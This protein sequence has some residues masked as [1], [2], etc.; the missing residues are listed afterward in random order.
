MRLHSSLS[1]GAYVKRK[2]TPLGTL[3]SKKIESFNF[4]RNSNNSFHDISYNEDQNS[5]IKFDQYSA[6]PSTSHSYISDNSRSISYSRQSVEVASLFDESLENFT[7]TTSTLLHSTIESAISENRHILCRSFSSGAGCSTALENLIMERR[8]IDPMQI[9][10]YMP[11]QHCREHKDFLFQARRVFPSLGSEIRRIQTILESKEFLK[12]Q[13]IEI[14]NVLQKSTL[15]IE[16]NSYLS[17]ENGRT[18]TQV[19][20]LISAISQH[21]QIVFLI[22]GVDSLH[23]RDNE[24][25]N[26]DDVQDF[27]VCFPSNICLLLSVQSNYGLC[28][29]WTQNGYITIDFPQIQKSQK[30]NLLKKCLKDKPYN[31]FAICN[32]VLLQ[33]LYNP[34]EI[35]IVVTHLVRTIDIIFKPKDNEQNIET[36][37]K[38][39]IDVSGDLNNMYVDDNIIELENCIESC[40]LYLRSVY[41]RQGLHGVIESTLDQLE[42]LFGNNGNIVKLFSLLLL[43]PSPVSLSY[44]SMFSGMTTNLIAKIVNTNSSLLKWIGEKN[45]IDATP[46]ENRAICFATYQA[47]ETI[48]YR[49]FGARKMLHQAEALYVRDFLHGMSSFTYATCVSFENI[50]P[51]FPTNTKLAAAV[52]MLNSACIQLHR[53]CPSLALEMVKNSLKMTRSITG[54][55]NIQANDEENKLNALQLKQALLILEKLC[56]IGTAGI[57]PLLTSKVKNTNSGSN[58]L[59]TRP[60]TRHK[61]KLKPVKKVSTNDAKKEQNGEGGGKSTNSMKAP[62]KTPESL[63]NKLQEVVN[64]KTIELLEIAFREEGEGVAALNR[65]NKAK[66]RKRVMPR[67]TKIKEI[68]NRHVSKLKAASIREKETFN[69]YTLSRKRFQ[70]ALRKV[71]AKKIFS[72]SDINVIFDTMSWKASDAS[73]TNPLIVK[74]VSWKTFVDILQSGAKERNFHLVTWERNEE[75]KIIQ[76][77]NLLSK[78]KRF[79]YIM[80]KIIEIPN[81]NMILRLAKNGLLSVYKKDSNSFLKHISLMDKDLIATDMCYIESSKVC[82]VTV[83]RNEPPAFSAVYFYEPLAEWLLSDIKINFKGLDSPPTAISSY[84]GALPAFSKSGKTTEL[85]DLLMIGCEDGTL[86]LGTLNNFVH[87]VDK[88][89]SISLL[90]SSSIINVIKYIDDF[91]VV[92]CGSMDG[93][94]YLFYFAMEGNIVDGLTMKE[95]QATRVFEHHSRPVFSLQYMSESQCILSAG[96]DEVI[97]LWSVSDFS[98]LSYIKTG[99][100]SKCAI[101]LEDVG[102]V[103][104]LDARVVLLNG[105]FHQGFRV[106]NLYGGKGLQMIE[107]TGSFPIAPLVSGAKIQES[108]VEGACGAL[109]YDPANDNFILGSHNLRRI[110]KRKRFSPNIFASHEKEIVSIFVLDSLVDSKSNTL[111]FL[112][113]DAAIRILSVS[114]L[115]SV[116][117]W[118]SHTGQNCGVFNIMNT[119]TFPTKG[120]GN[121]NSSVEVCSATCDIACTRVFIGLTNGLVTAWRILNGKFISQYYAMEKS[122]VRSLSLSPNSDIL[123]SGLDNGMTVTWNLEDLADGTSDLINGNFLRPTSSILHESQVTSISVINFEGTTFLFYGDKEPGISYWKY[124]KYTPIDVLG[125]QWYFGKNRQEVEDGITEMCQM[126]GAPIPTI[127]TSCGDGYLRIYHSSYFHRLQLLEQRYS[128][129]SS[130]ETTPCTSIACRQTH[131]ISAN[132]NKNLFAQESEFEKKHFKIVVSDMGGGIHLWSCTIVKFLNLIYESFPIQLMKDSSWNINDNDHPTLNAG[133][134]CFATKVDICNDSRYV[135]AAGNDNRIYMYLCNGILLGTFGQD[136][137]WK[138]PKSKKELNRYVMRSNM[139]IDRKYNE[140]DDDVTNG[141]SPAEFINTPNRRNRGRAGVFSSGDDSTGTIPFSRESTRWKTAPNLYLHNTIKAINIINDGT[142][143][144]ESLANTGEIYHITSDKGMEALKKLATHTISPSLITKNLYVRRP[145]TTT[146]DKEKEK[147]KS[148]LASRQTKILPQTPLQTFKSIQIYTNLGKEGEEGSGDVVDGEYI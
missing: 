14:L 132:V 144:D 142:I 123:C 42:E 114:A 17:N 111:N 47:W 28:T 76:P 128:G 24:G 58:N 35:S 19:S 46:I 82:A 83:R 120:G 138:L 59:M 108:N 143:R 81:S 73:G 29:T 67:L 15:M 69:T 62:M 54:A 60:L 44:L 140:D 32:D 20:K 16:N 3:T 119:L 92:I 97:L 133:K 139:Q 68:N 99:I 147:L 136:G 75:D 11:I 145:L 100:S 134:V 127:V 91:N 130:D 57:V 23:D 9:T 141:M 93:N 106:W 65:K 135:I 90:G 7:Y 109:L 116:R 103:I 80:D 110:Q 2:G 104:S 53:N 51:S 74:T 4:S 25:T 6:P 56:E 95:K 88:T 49:Y 89:M 63:L 117:T 12:D 61:S 8:E 64:G 84:Y 22:D 41:L 38:K 105:H 112:D 43:S 26:Y 48:K 85:I 34:L 148:R 33:E 36:E 40:C 72:D 45:E 1:S 131:S 55:T 39:G 126:D 18:T 70:N 37:D 125:T 66:A 113:D 107:L 71:F 96:L 124:K 129:G 118:E 86:R 98:V 87:D 77:R 31:Y 146:I 5:S 122:P 102:Q 10:S 121:N 94:V 27:L 78:P 30:E 52:G 115:G 21:L 13:E 137:A 50:Y 101:G 79:R